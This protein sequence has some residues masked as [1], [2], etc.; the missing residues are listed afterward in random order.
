ML[1]FQSLYPY[2]PTGLIP[3]PWKQHPTLCH[4]PHP[5]SRNS[6][7]L[8]LSEQPLP[9][10]PKCQYSILPKTKKHSTCFQTL[11]NCSQIGQSKSSF[12]I[13]TKITKMFEF[14]FILQNHFRRK[15]G[16]NFI[17]I[18]NRMETNIWIFSL[19][20]ILIGTK[21]NAMFC[22][23]PLAIKGCAWKTSTYQ[24]KRQFLSIL[25][26]VRWELQTPHWLYLPLTCLHQSCPE[27]NSLLRL[28]GKIALAFKMI[29][30]EVYSLQWR[31]P[32]YMDLFSLLVSC[33]FG[34]LLFESFY[35]SS[36]K[37]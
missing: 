36:T 34:L 24:N 29:L 22:T 28:E 3:H 27:Y 21:K 25:E 5:K 8:T 1:N 15:L 6:L 12:H 32:I 9:W 18:G 13:Y 10:P 4:Q 19:L 23:T 35:S 7:N 11:T 37:N 17:P 14:F 30:L 2:F 16:E 26:C 20:Q 33:W 31:Q